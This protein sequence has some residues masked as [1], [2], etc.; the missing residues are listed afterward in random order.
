[1]WRNNDI[2]FCKKN[3]DFSFSKKARGMEI[4]TPQKSPF[5]MMECSVLIRSKDRY[6]LY[7]DYK[8]LSVDLA[9]ITDKP[10]SYKQVFSNVIYP[11]DYAM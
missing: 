3:K 10:H 11:L 6:I 4:I 7:A 9:V 2:L 8:N 1:M 5:F